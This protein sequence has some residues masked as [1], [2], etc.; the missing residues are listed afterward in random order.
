MDP[1]GCTVVTTVERQT[2]REELPCTYY[3]RFTD[4]HADIPKPLTQFTE[5][6]WSTQSSPETAATFQVLGYHLLGD[7]FIVDTGANNVRIGGVPC[8]RA[9]SV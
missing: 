8:K 5:Q 4:G 1:K 7:R 6:K 3:Q 9:R 2:P